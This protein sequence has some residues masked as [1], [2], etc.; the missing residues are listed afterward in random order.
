M[1]KW[2]CVDLGT[3]EAMYHI[4]TS[5]RPSVSPTGEEDRGWDPSECEFLLSDT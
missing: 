3:T 5:I 1:P 4:S 2:A